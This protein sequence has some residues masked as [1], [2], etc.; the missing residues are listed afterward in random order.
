MV[1]QLDRWRNQS[2]C[3]K[4]VERK[5]GQFKLNKSYIFD[6]SCKSHLDHSMLL[7]MSD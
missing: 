2:T 3:H 7:Q 1:Q 6:C 4:E 5:A